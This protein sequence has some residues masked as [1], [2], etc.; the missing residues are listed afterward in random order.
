MCA[1]TARRVRAETTGPQVGDPTARS[2][3]V[4]RTGPPAGDPT[5]RCVQAETTG[6][7]VGAQLELNVGVALP[8]LVP[9][10][11]GRRRD[12]MARPRVPE[13]SFRAKHDRRRVA[14]RES[15]GMDRGVPTEHQAAMAIPGA[16]HP[17]VRASQGSVAHGARMIRSPVRVRPD[18]T[19]TSG[20]LA[21]GGISDRAA[22]VV[23]EGRTHGRE[24]AAVRKGKGRRSARLLRDRRAEPSLASAGKSVPRRVGLRTQPLARAGVRRRRMG[25]VR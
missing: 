18:V 13:P 11:N 7:Q 10:G 2:V 3:Q 5:A 16:P 1:L 22:I 23:R 21:G 19:A 12:A 9:W 8:D 24:A 20:G 17:I 6:P 4:E 15:A 25:L 14:K